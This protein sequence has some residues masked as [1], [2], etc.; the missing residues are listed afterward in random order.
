MRYERALTAANAATS[1]NART[2]S[3]FGLGAIVEPKEWGAALP[4][5][6]DDP[7]RAAHDVSYPRLVT[8]ALALCGN[9]AEAEDIVQEAFVMAMTHRRDFAEVAIKDAWLRT[10]AVRLLRRRWRRKRLVGRLMPRMRTELS[11][12]L[13]P[14]A[15]EDHVAVV[16]A[17]SQLELPVRETVALRYVANLGV[18][19]IA[20]ELGV[21]EGIVKARLARARAQMAGH[22]VE[23]EESD[24]V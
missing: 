7:I 1:A 4:M 20:R 21:P 3:G 16:F 23:R 24:H 10:T 18:E 15:P 11:I 6:H 13:G 22:L 9:L 17:L 14:D 12:D 19:Q 2:A 8:Q 5:D